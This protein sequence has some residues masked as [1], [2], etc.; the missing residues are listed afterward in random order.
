MRFIVRS[1]RKDLSRGR[2]ILRTGRET[3]LRWRCR[4]VRLTRQRGLP[5]RSRGTVKRNAVPSLTSW[6][7]CGSCKTP[8]SRLC[9][10][11]PI[12]GGGGA[13]RTLGIFMPWSLTWTE[14]VCPSSGIRCIRWTRIFCPR[15][16]LL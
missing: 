9:P 13:A 12:L 2:A 3:E 11:S 16:P 14:W 6:T 8:I 7:S 5:C 15:Q 4:K 1:S 10:R